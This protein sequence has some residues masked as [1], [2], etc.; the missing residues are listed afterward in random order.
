MTWEDPREREWEGSS[1]LATGSIALLRDR[2]ELTEEELRA[3][4]ELEA[5]R[6]P[7]G[8]R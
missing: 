7:F 4:E 5:R 2:D 3:I 6:L 8:F 1:D